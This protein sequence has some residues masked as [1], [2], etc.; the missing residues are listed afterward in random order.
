MK[1]GDMVG[2]SN[3]D[4]QTGIVLGIWSEWAED[5]VYT[6]EEAIQTWAQILWDDGDISDH[7]VD[8]YSWEL[9]VIIESR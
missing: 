6:G 7:D 4:G 2:Y 3:G 9:E 8:C 1:I 5:N